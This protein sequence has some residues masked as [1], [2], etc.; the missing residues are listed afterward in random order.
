MS[1]TARQMLL[2]LDL[3]Y[4]KDEDIPD[5]DQVL[6]MNDVWAWATSWGEHVPDD[7]LI[8]VARLVRLYGYCGAYYWVSHKHDNMRSEFEDIN[9][10]VEFVRQEEA[11]R[12]EIPGSSAR[13]YAKRSYTIGDQ[14]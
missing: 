10:F 5:G 1:D 14:P 4:G 9:R 11:I 7:E 6:N 3:V 8:E 2:A 12:D 13:A